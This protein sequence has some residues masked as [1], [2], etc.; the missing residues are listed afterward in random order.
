VDVL[1]RARINPM[2]KPAATQLWHQLEVG[3]WSVVHH[4]DRDRQRYLLAREN[5]P[6]AR[7]TRALTPR[8]RQ[9]VECA[10]HGWSNKVIAFELGISS[11][12]VSTHLSHAAAKLGLSSRMAV[13]ELFVALAV[14]SPPDASVSYVG[15]AGKKFAVFAIP[16]GPDLPEILS[17]A[18]RDVVTLVVAGKSN[19]AIAQA[20]G[21][22]ARTVENQLAAAMKKLGVSSRANLT[23]FLMSRAT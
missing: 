15:W 14:K 20:R 2:E 16:T 6:S 21:V 8:E 12:S 10:S 18:E 23:A 5:A 13:I 7:G 4:L 22:S 17:P 19:A 9:I 3:S 1:D 11:S